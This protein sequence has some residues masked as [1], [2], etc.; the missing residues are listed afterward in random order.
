[1]KKHINK[2]IILLATLILFATF[3]C[4]SAQQSLPP[5]TAYEQQTSTP[6]APTATPAPF[7]SV[8]EDELR[9]DDGMLVLVNYEHFYSYTNEIKTEP[10][11]QNEY[12][13]TDRA[14]IELPSLM[15]QALTEL[16]K[17]FYEH[18]GYRLYITS[19]YRTEQYQR[20]LYDN[21]VI[22]HGEEMAKIYV[23]SPG[24]SEHHTGFAVDLSTVDADLQRTP[25]EYHPDREWFGK[26]C[27][28]YGF[29][30]RYPIG[31]EQITH[32]A[33]E[34]WHFRYLGVPVA[35]AVTALGITYEE[36]IE[37][38]K[39]YSPQTGMLFVK[40]AVIE[41]EQ[42]DG[43][44]DVVHYNETDRTFSLTGGYVIYF[45]PE[46]QPIQIPAPITDYIVSGTND[47]GF[48]VVGRV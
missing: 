7:F 11:E 16:G 24:A 23:A 13:L 20:Q 8:A 30:L 35:H 17:V 3:G 26:I 32:V 22:D 5:Q 14:D 10:I 38:I 21:Y 4:N 18:N 45:V 39:Q 1:M 19:G 41:F 9:T 27:S 40:D 28:D 43:Y 47:G 15:T 6:E 42:Q 29:I 31:S 46:Q 48:I 33:Y 25:L 2:L 34:P 36:F 37:Q 44:I 12:L